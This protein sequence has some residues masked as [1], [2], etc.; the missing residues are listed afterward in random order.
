M[1]KIYLNFS[2]LIKLFIQFYFKKKF[3]K[4]KYSITHLNFILQKFIQ[5]ILEKNL[6][7]FSN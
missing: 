4:E 3:Q 1:K 2:N 6:F 5:Y 7:K